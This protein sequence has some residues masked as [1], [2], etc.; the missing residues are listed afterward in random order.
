MTKFGGQPVW[1][2]EPQWPVNDAWDEPMRFICQIDLE[3]VL[4]E[5]GRGRLAYVFITHAQHGDDTFFDPDTAFPDEGANAIIVQ[6]GGAY[7]GPT[8]P[9]ATGPTLFHADDGSDAEYALQ[10]IPDTDPDFRP[11]H[12]PGTPPPDDHAHYWEQISGDKIGGTPAF[13]QDD[14]WPDNGPWTLAL[15]LSPN[16]QPFHLNLGAAPTTFAFVSPDATQGRLL[17]QDT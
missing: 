17:I 15:Q 9:T 1:L 14:D 8:L 10:L 12:Q 3:T 2:C 13:F 7:H 5:A 6:P 4:G 16:F 11:Q